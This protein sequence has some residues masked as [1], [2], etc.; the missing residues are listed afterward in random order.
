MRIFIHE[1]LDSVPSLGPR[2]ILKFPAKKKQVI[3]ELSYLHHEN[4]YRDANDKRK[5]DDEDQ[6]LWTLALL[7]R[8]GLNKRAPRRVHQQYVQTLAALQRMRR[9]AGREPFKRSRRP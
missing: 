3:G 7:L 2:P 4:Q 1:S 6:S 9:L 5:V 8:Q